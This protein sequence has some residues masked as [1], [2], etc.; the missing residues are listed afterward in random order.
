MMW[1]QLAKNRSSKEEKKSFEV[2]CGS[3]KRLCTDLEYRKCQSDVSPARKAARLLPSSHYKKKYLSPASTA[4]R[5]KAA[6]AER[7]ADKAKL[8]KHEELDVPLDDEQS[9]EL[10]AIMKRIEETYSNELDKIF[11]EGDD[12]A[13]GDLVRNSWEKDKL[14]AKSQFYKDQQINGKFSDSYC[15]FV[16][17]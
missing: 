2:L 17:G 13:V 3:C 9:D 16:T 1:H 14:N 8:A 12:H 5:N 6:Q 7:S 10:C 4:V 15:L 11:Q